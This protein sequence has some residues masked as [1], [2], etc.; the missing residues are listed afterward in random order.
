MDELKEKLESQRK[1][2]KEQ[3]ERFAKKDGNLKGDWDTMFPEMDKGATGSA[4][5][6]EGADEVQ[7][8]AN[9]LPVEHSLELRLQDIERALEKIENGDY[10]RCGN[11]G[12]EIG[13]ERLKIYPE[14]KYCQDCQ[15]KK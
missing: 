8:Y 2:I 7:E 1:E 9:M 15:G 14:A 5:L 11:C 10:G 6:E 4:Q 12:K 13:D 3:L